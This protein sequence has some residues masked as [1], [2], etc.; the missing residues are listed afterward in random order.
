MSAAG[1]AQSSR[2]GVARLPGNP[3]DMSTPGPGHWAQC[4]HVRTRVPRLDMS[5]GL[6]EHAHSRPKTGHVPG[7]GAR[8]SPGPKTGHVHSRP[9]P[10]GTMPPCPHPGP[11]AGHVRWAQGTCPFP[12]PKAGHVHSRPRPLGTMPPCPH[13]GPKA[14][15][16]L[17]PRDTSIPLDTMAGPCPLPAPRLD[18][19]GWAQCHHVRTRAP[20]LDMSGGRREHAH[21]R[22][23]RLDMSGGRRGMST[24]GFRARA[25]PPAGTS[26][27]RNQPRHQTIRGPRGYEWPV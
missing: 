11:K 6:R 9:R 17:W 15:H 14:G 22:V 5:A 18:M 16:V 12:G 21:A 13:P 25:C 7:P 23:P 2:S 24:H 19:S 1:H 10:L 26:P 4:H 8:Q 20:R 3:R 27:P